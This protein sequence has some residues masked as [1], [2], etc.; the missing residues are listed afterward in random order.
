MNE[1]DA[2]VAIS[3]DLTEL[4]FEQD[5]NIHN[6]ESDQMQQMKKEINAPKKQHL[7]L[8]QEAILSALDEKGKR[9]LLATSEKRASSWL[10]VLP[11]EKLGYAV[12]K[13]EFRDAVPKIWVTY[14]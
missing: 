2:S 10:S 3:Y 11:L 6:L 5:L 14:T 13:Q 8:E 4:I 9:L 7:Q 1:Y 12:N